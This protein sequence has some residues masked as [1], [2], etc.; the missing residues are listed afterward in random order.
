MNI[1]IVA[2]LIAGFTSFFSPCILPLIPGYI[3]YLAGDKKKGAVLKSLLFIVGFTSIFMIL[4]TG[5]GFIGQFLLR[6]K[7]I[8]KIISG[9]IIIIFAL[10]A[11][12]KLNIKSLNKS[13]SVKFKSKHGSFFEP[14]IMGLTF[15]LSWSPC[16][17]PVLSSILLYAA[18]AQSAA[19]GSFLLFV[20][21]MAMAI[22]FILIAVFID[23]FQDFML[24][25][26]R[27]FENVTKISAVFLLIFGIYVIF[28]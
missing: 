26:E 8:L 19:Y 6:N 24:K 20:Y 13:Y 10:F 23:K 11:F 3:F 14:L 4:G 1:N 17:G 7:K 27:L 9:V 5:A 22:P 12:G 28:S 15:A 25:H 18:S 16:F 21:S 2:A